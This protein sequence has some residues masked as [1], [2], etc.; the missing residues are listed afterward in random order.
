MKIFKYLL[1]T[2]SFIILIS[3]CSCDGNPQPIYYIGEEYIF[4]T[5]T[6]KVE[7]DVAEEKYILYYTVNEDDTYK[8]SFCF[9]FHLN[10]SETLINSTEFEYSTSDL[11]EVIEFDENG[12]YCFYGSRIFYVSYKNANEEI[13]NSIKNKECSIYC[14]IGLFKYYNY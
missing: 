14:F 2:V 10:A 7:D 9:E 3:G 5:V 11:D 12:Y 13:K 1:V 8:H 6:V 4:D